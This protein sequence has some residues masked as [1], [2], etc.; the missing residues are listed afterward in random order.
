MTRYQVFHRARRFG[1]VFWWVFIA[2]TMVAGGIT[3]F[4][5]AEPDDFGWTAYTP[6]PGLPRRYA[7]YL[8]SDGFDI[9]PGMTFLAFCLLV[10]AALAEA[11]ALRRA[12]AGIITVAVPFV[13]TAL[14]WSAMPRGHSN[15]FLTPIPALLAILVAVAV[16]ELS[17]RKIVWIP[18]PTTP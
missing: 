7:D 18:T 1:Y 12:L 3:W 8:P 14:I 11:V 17:A 6:R 16:R 10:L 2:A 13:A 9:T 5:G 4:D 15:F